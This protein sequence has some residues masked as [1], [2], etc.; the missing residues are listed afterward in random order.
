MCS[1]LLCPN[2]VKLWRQKASQVFQ[3]L[4]MTFWVNR[5]AFNV[6]PAVNTLLPWSW[7]RKTRCLTQKEPGM[8]IESYLIRLEIWEKRGMIPP[9]F[10]EQS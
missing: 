9:V 10:N 7:L 1:I 4:G 5:L 2:A 8:R 6:C 3:V